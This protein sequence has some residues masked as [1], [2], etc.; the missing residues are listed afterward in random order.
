[1]SHPKFRSYAP[2][3]CKVVKHLMPDLMSNG[4]RQPGSTSDRMLR[5]AR[6]HVFAVTRGKTY[7]EIIQTA[8]EQIDNLKNLKQPVGYVPPESHKSEDRANCVLQDKS[9]NIENNQKAPVK[10]PVTKRTGRDEN[11]KARIKRQIIFD[12]VDV[13]SN[14]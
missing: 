13:R 8:K 4:P 7:E 1:M 12:D 2:V 10:S 5:I 14:R 6:Q 11:S 9:L 3:L